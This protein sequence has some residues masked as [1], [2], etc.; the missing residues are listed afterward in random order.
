[1]RTCLIDADGL[2]YVVVHCKKQ[3]NEDGSPLLDALGAQ[4]VE[5]KTLDDCKLQ[6]D[7]LI[8]TILN[9]TKSD[10]YLLFLTVG[11]NFRYSIYPE[12]KGNRKQGDKPEHFDRVKEYL[13]TEYKAIYDTRLE[14]DD[15]CMIYRALIEDSFISS[16]DKDVLSTQG[17]HFDSKNFKWVQTNEELANHMFWKDMIIGQFGDN[18]KGIPGIG[19]DNKIFKEGGF[20]ASPDYVLNL[21][22]SKLGEKLGIEE[23]YKNY[24][25]LTI[26]DK[27]DGLE[28]QTPIE[29]KREF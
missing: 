8:K 2:I 26:L 11:K 22:I 4:V 3:Y 27:Y 5:T 15:L 25:C 21:Y 14:A 29:Y 10:S 1:M 24:K 12:Y 19:K 7:T 23:F 16:P 13:I 28:I 6:M 9:I 20:I 18:I 17:N